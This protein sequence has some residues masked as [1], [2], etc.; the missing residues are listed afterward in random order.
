MRKPVFGVS[1]RSDTNRTVQP[2][3]MARGLNFLRLNS[4]MVK[5]EE[6]V[7]RIDGWLVYLIIQG[8]RAKHSFNLAIVFQICDGDRMVVSQG[9]MILELKS[10]K[11][12]VVSLQITRVCV[13]ARQSLQPDDSNK[14]T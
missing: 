3:K 7:F 8:F 9:M 2:Q 11:R 13:Y 5:V 10:V 12:S 4:S 14:P 1:T 6:Q